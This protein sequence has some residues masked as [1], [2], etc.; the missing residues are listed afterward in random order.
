MSCIICG[1]NNPLVRES[2]LS[3]FH[4]KGHTIKLLQ[5]GE[6]CNSCSEGILTGDDMA[7]T[8]PTMKKF[9]EL[10][11][12]IPAKNQNF[13][14]ELKE[15]TNQISKLLN[16]KE[17]IEQLHLPEVYYLHGL[18]VAYNKLLIS[19][20]DDTITELKDRIEKL[21]EMEKLGRLGK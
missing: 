8:E 5:S 2:R 21:E 17:L 18:K 7:Q 14:S 10:I 6:W 12:N 9:W 20:R 16:V 19:N 11:D 13:F 1:S 3:D 4:Y 15:R